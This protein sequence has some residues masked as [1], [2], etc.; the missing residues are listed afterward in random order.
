ML[1]LEAYIFP[2]ISEGGCYLA[3]EAETFFKP[4]TGVALNHMAIVRLHTLTK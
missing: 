1:K 2:Q 3:T 4:L